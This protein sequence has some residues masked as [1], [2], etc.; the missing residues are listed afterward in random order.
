MFARRSARPSGLNLAKSYLYTRT[1]S[2][3]LRFA[4][5]QCWDHRAHLVDST[6]TTRKS[7]GAWQTASF[8]PRQHR[9]APEEA[10]QDNRRRGAWLASEVL[11][12]VRRPGTELS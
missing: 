4:Y 1:Q 7:A 9:G 5:R 12:T 10:V 8:A 2:A 6:R 3:V 11:A